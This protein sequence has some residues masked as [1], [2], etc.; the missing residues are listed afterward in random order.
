MDVSV[1][2]VPALL[3]EGEKW[4]RQSEGEWKGRE[5]KERE[6]ER[7]FILFVQQEEDAFEKRRESI[8]KQRTCSQWKKN[9][10]GIYSKNLKIMLLSSCEACKLL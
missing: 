10:D 5:L 9:N 6:R 1:V 2:C 8:D 7:N 3:K 4:E